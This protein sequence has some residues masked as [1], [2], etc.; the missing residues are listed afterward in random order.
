MRKLTLLALFTF[1]SIVCNSQVG[2]LDN[3][4]GNNG[5]VQTAVRT[6]LSATAVQSGGRIVAAGSLQTEDGK[7]SDF[8][9]V[10]YNPDGTPDQS[11]GNDGI[12]TTDFEIGDD[13]ILCSD[14]A[15]W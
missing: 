9:I 12:V 15:R 10:R 4:F 1:A 14:P 7:G 8:L 6:S 3:S 13:V 11:F 5:F 2:F